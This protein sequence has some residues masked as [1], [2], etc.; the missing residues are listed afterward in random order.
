MGSVEVQK[1]T[2]PSFKRLE[3]GSVNI[4]P[5]KF[6]ATSTEPADANAVAKEI[7][8]AF[9]AAIAKEDPIAITDLFAD[10]S[11]WRDHLALTWDVRTFTGKD[12]IKQQ[13]NQNGCGPHLGLPRAPFCRF[14]WCGQVQGH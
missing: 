8:D 3:P 4:L 5:H 6:N 13:L 9:S 7:I 1:A 2:V 11:F 14:R 10:D 12:Q